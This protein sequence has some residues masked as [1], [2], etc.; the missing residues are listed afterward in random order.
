MVKKS[1]YVDTDD[2]RLYY[3]VTGQGEA[4]VFLHGNGGSSKEFENNIKDFSSDYCCI[5]IDMRLQGRSGKKT[6]QELTYELFADDV[7]KVLDNLNIDKFFVIGFSDGAITAITLAQKYPQRVKKMVLIG[8]NYNVS[9]LNNFELF[10]MKTIRT[11]FGVLSFI[12]YFKR[13]YRLFS[14][15]TKYPNFT[16]QDLKNINISALVMAGQHDM[17][18]DEH[19]KALAQ[20]LGARLEIVKNAG[21]FWHTKKKEILKE[22]AYAFFR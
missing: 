15:M 22:K 7:I 21:H 10:V 17:I 11:I 19:T 4:L 1:G 13:Q 8:A 3:E 18:K 12:T 5:A 14:L 2:C 20:A 6:K 16:T 9:G